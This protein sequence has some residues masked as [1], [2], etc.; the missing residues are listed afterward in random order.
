M[1][2]G[3]IIDD[4]DAE[5]VA[6]V[7]ELLITSEDE[8]VDGIPELPALDDDTIREILVALDE[9]ATIE[10]DIK[11]EETPFEDAITLEEAMLMDEDGTE[12]IEDEMPE[13]PMVLLL[14]GE[15]ED[16]RML[17]TLL[18]DKVA[19]TLTE[20]DAE[21]IV[22]IVVVLAE[23]EIVEATVAT[24]EL[25]DRDPVS[26]EELVERAK[27]LLEAKE[28]DETIEIVELS[29]AAP[30]SDEVEVEF[31]VREPVYV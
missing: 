7:V 26:V 31:L 29:V 30:V 11:L 13:L 22:E 17:I 2:A 8:D 3:Q 12:L 25:E 16:P 10:E 6:L 18:L 15:I 21:E 23:L 1:E 20:L 27:E 19:K 5:L 14:D 24:L 4:G 9:A 28:L